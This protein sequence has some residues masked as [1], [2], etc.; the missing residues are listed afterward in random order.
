M[1]WFAARGDR[2]GV[3]EV[4]RRGRGLVGRS[5]QSGHRSRSCGVGV[6]GRRRHRSVGVP[7][8]WVLRWRTWS[9]IKALRSG[10][11]WGSSRVRS[12]RR[13][14]GHRCSRWVISLV[15]RTGW[16]WRISIW[17]RRR[18]RSVTIRDLACGRRRRPLK[19][20][21]RHMRR[22]CVRATLCKLRSLRGHR[23][24]APWRRRTAEDVV[25]GGISLYR[26]GTVRPVIP[27]TLPPQISHVY[28]AGDS[29]GRL[30]VSGS[31]NNF[32]YSERLRRQRRDKKGEGIRVDRRER[33]GRRKMVCSRSWAAE[34][35]REEQKWQSHKKQCD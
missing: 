7:R 24:R 14:S 26:R 31:H 25:I 18:R 15:F 27:V 1:I 33:S 12:R 35:K 2:R 5:I 3:I 28:Q 13:L 30:R 6:Q 21:L 8:I 4:A 10:V 11:D 16:C 29:Q 9:R 32:F 22:H 17:R 20:R 19:L 23:L 34:G